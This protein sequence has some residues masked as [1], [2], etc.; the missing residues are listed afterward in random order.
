MN[1]S[2]I[3]IIV[4]AGTAQGKSTVAESIRQGLTIM[5]LKVTLNDDNGIGIQDEKPGVIAASLSERLGALIG[6]A[7]EI[8]IRTLQAKTRP[9]DALTTQGGIK[10]GEMMV[11]AAGTG[12]K[13]M[14]GRTP[15]TVVSPKPFT[16]EEVRSMLC[17]A[18]V[19][20]QSG[21][22]L[23]TNWIDSTDL[24]PYV[25]KF[26]ELLNKRLAG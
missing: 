8:T 14:F 15:P 17:A 5:G 9:L 2:K 25:D 23:G 3:N 18:G 19:T 12:G 6:R 10:A 16:K 26:T 11:L 24:T 1:D 7:P 21:N 22:R 4:Q 13:S 20:Y